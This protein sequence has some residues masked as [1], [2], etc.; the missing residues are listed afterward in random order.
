MVGAQNR[1]CLSSL[2]EFAFFHCLLV[3]LVSSLEDFASP[4]TSLRLVSLLPKF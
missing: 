4:R 1:G 2:L 3:E